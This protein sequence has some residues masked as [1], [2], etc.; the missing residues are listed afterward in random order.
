MQACRKDTY[1]TLEG[2]HGPSLLE[3]LTEMT[4][5]QVSPGGHLENLPAIAAKIG[6]ELRNQYVLGYTPSNH[7]YDGQWRKIRVRLRP[8]RGV[9][10]LLV[11]AKTGYYAKPKQLRTISR[12]TSMDGL[13]DALESTETNGDLRSEPLG[14]LSAA[15]S[16]SV[17]KP[18][19]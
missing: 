4:G 18:S 15:R 11:H 10:P 3:E 14:C 6:A 13:C 19:S 17:H 16:L 1:K 2:I 7:V 8:P 9:A 5:G 12:A